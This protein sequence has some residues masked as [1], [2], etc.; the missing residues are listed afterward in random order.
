ML[1]TRDNQSASNPLAV[2]IR[3]SEI[4]TDTLTDSYDVIQ[5][6]PILSDIKIR[7][8]KITPFVLARYHRVAAARKAIE[9]STS[10]LVGLKACLN[11]IKS[12]AIKED[13]GGNSI[14]QH[15]EE[16]IRVLEAEIEFINGTLA[17]IRS[18]PVL[19]YDIG[20]S[21]SST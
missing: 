3:R 16:T 20:E 14:G 4:N 2:A 19:F 18:W 8:T 6:T 17:M 13:E 7:V 9:D 11:T 12:Q 5:H 15:D 1:Q 21:G 10:V